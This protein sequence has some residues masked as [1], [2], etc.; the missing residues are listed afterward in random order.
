VAQNESGPAPGQKAST[1]GDIPMAKAVRFFS[2]MLMTAL[3][4]TCCPHEGRAND[5]EANLAAGG[6]V[7]AKNNAIEL[8][9]EE[10]FISP[11]KIIVDYIFYNRTK[12]DVK[13]TVAFSSAR[14]RFCS[15]RRG[16]YRRPYR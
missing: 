3:I 16:T 9:S 8:R 11:K 4:Y 15:R 1:I 10:L 12:R 2:A 13:I 5:S 14:S 7:L 6:L